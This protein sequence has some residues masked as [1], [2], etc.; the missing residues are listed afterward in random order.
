MVLSSDERRTLLSCRRNVARS[1]RS[2]NVVQ[3][4]T[5]KCS[6]AQRDIV[7]HAWPPPLAIHRR[8]GALIGA[9]KHEGRPS[10]PAWR[11]RFAAT[12]LHVACCMSW[13][14][15]YVPCELPGFARPAAVRPL[16]ATACAAAAAAVEELGPM[17]TA[18][19]AG[20][21]SYS[22]ISLQSTCWPQSSTRTASSESVLHCGD[23]PSAQSQCRCGQG[24]PSLGADVARGVPGPVMASG[25]FIRE[26]AR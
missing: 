25:E 22:Q 4:S 3:H 10:G 9:V 24:E 5:A 18:V 8:Y 1:A 19:L 16:Q 20:R 17:P 23:G 6:I 7:L 21:S 12:P 14:T 15:F 13:P 26:L 2:Y 11:V